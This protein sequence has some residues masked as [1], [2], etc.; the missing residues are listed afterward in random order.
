MH[1]CSHVHIYRVKLLQANNEHIEPLIS[2]LKASLHTMTLE[3]KA[4]VTQL[5]K[6]RVQYTQI[7]EQVE[8][9]FKTSEDLCKASCEGTNVEL[10]RLTA[11]MTQLRSDPSASTSTN[12]QRPL[13]RLPD[14]WLSFQKYYKFLDS[15]KSV[16]LS[17]GAFAC[18]LKQAVELINEQITDIS[19]NVS[20]ELCSLHNKLWQ[21]A[22]SLFLYYYCTISTSP[23]P[24][25][26]LLLKPIVSHN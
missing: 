17:F 4:S 16:L 19:A 7:N 12:T 3:H 15:L 2:S 8:L 20:R 14:V 11:E 9:S 10:F 26:P 13:T 5:E 22:V 21:H 6:L 25:F 18:K 1:I 24:C 23:C